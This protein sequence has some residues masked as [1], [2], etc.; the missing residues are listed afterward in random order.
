MQCRAL[1]AAA[2][3]AAVTVAMATTERASSQVSGGGVELPEAVLSSASGGKVA[4]PGTVYRAVESEVEADGCLIFEA[5]STSFLLRRPLRL[6][7]SRGRV[8]IIIDSADR[9]LRSD[10]RL[11]H[12]TSRSGSEPRGPVSH[13]RLRTSAIRKDGTV[14]ARR[15]DFRIDPMRD[16]YLALR[17]FKPRTA[18]AK[19][20]TSWSFAVAGRDA[21]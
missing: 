9:L 4:I 8:R 17:T 3:A 13:P 18:C 16:N 11:W 12:R 7:P 10:L 6:V 15:L 20:R 21:G 1:T 14:V 19:E 5:G 2:A